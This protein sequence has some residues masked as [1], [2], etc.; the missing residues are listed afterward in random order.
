MQPLDIAVI[1][2]NSLG[3]VNNSTSFLSIF[4]WQVLLYGQNFTYK[5]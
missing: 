4:I 1:K 2:M 5:C 3:S